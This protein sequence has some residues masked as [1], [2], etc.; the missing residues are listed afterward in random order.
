[1]IY[2]NNDGNIYKINDVVTIDQNPEIFKFI[3]DYM[4]HCD[5]KC[6]I[7][8]A[9][10]L[11]ILACEYE[12]SELKDLCY[13]HIIMNLNQ[14]NAYSMLVNAQNSKLFDEVNSNLRDSCIN[15]IMSDQ[16]NIPQNVISEMSNRN[17][18]LFVDRLIKKNNELKEKNKFDIIDKWANICVGKKRI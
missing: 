17:I 11:M 15:Y 13:T 4:Y 14:N 5:I 8:E 6:T 7:S 1:M 18:K 3:L 9:F 16:I 2:V 12:L 10:E